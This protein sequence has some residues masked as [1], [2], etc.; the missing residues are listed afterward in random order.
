[1]CALIVKCI[2]HLLVDGSKSRLL[3]TSPRSSNVGE[4][5][6]ESLRT[7]CNSLKNGVLHFR[8]WNESNKI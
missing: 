3:E 1:M 8:Y 2:N 4:V 7:A 6:E 5:A